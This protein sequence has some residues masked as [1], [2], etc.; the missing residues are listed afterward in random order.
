MLGVTEAGA[1]GEIY[2]ECQSTILGKCGEVPVLLGVPPFVPRVGLHTIGDVSRTQI[3]Q[4]DYRFR[5]IR[6]MY[7]VVWVRNHILL[8]GLWEDQLVSFVS[9]VS[10][11]STS[12]SFPSHV[13]RLLETG[14]PYA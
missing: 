9:F 2:P 11:P 6:K 3:C 7:T 1:A 10:L 12:C 5:E 14:S 13:L 4:G 8:R